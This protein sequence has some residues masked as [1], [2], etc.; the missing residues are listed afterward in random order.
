M[1]Y[2]L[3]YHCSIPSGPFVLYMC[4]DCGGTR[5]VDQPSYYTVNLVCKCCYP[6][7][8]TEMVQVWPAQEGKSD[9]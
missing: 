9:A 8:V 2:E 5:K 4:P 7:H 1:T 6:D 3:N